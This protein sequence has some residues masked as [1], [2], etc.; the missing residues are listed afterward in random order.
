MRF[1]SACIC[2]VGMRATR[3]AM[4]QIF[5]TF[6]AHFSNSLVSPAPKP[7]API[8]TYAGSPC[9]LK[10]TFLSLPPVAPA[11]TSA[12]QPMIFSLLSA[13]VTSQVFHILILEWVMR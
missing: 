7:V 4:N 5:S 10:T 11:A 3:Q 12:T 9:E 6:P 13:A 1:K 2:A 8:C